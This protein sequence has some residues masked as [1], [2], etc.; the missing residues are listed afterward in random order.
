[1]ITETT[2]TNQ[3]NRFEPYLYLAFELSQ[4]QWKLGFTIG[5]AQRPRIRNISARDLQALQ[6]EIQA[7]KKRFGLPADAPVLSCYEA[8][9]EGFWIHRY[10]EEIWY[11]EHSG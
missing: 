9:R 7:A 6:D 8:G 11:S 2:L 4:N 10:L 3:Y 1:M 5:V